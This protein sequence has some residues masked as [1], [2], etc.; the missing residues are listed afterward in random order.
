MKHAG[1]DTYFRNVND[2]IARVKEPSL[3]VRICTP[4]FVEQQ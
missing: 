1:K 2:F 3:S 4:A